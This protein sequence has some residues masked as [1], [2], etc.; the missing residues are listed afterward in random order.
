MAGPIAVARLR[1]LAYAR[2]VIR[3]VLTLRSWLLCLTAVWAL[4][5]AWIVPSAVFAATSTTT[6]GGGTSLL[7]SG[8]AGSGEEAGEESS[9]ASKSST[10]GTGSSAESSSFTSLPVIGGMAAAA[11]LIAGIAYFITRDARRNAPVP[12]GA[13][14]NA[15]ARM[16][17]D[18]A[19]KRRAK[20]KA[21]K[22]QRKRN[23]P[24]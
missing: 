15:S 11:L 5:T 2:R 4:A 7:E 1:R 10:T 21:A 9:G 23:R 22:Q 3:R 24:R 17:P 20:A 14:A 16:S 18:H 8:G 19:R 13:L 6:P 12:E